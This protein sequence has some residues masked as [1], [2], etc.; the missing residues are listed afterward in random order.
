MT[1]ETSHAGQRITLRGFLLGF[2]SGAFAVLLLFAGIVYHNRTPNTD[3]WSSG[4][5]V[6]G[7]PEPAPAYPTEAQVAEA[8]VDMETTLLQQANE[9]PH[10]EDIQRAVRQAR[11]KLT[12]AHLDYKT[13]RNIPED[14][15]WT[16][17][18]QEMEAMTREFLEAIE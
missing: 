16:R 8:V 7:Q 14:V 15:R 1:T 6:L 17:F 9:N 2:I 11:F 13:S 12:A 18:E 3:S 10:S 5:S 4:E